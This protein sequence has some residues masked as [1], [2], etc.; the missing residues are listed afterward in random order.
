MFRSLLIIILGGVLAWLI[1]HLIR[2][3]RQVMPGEPAKPADP[4]QNEK[5]IDAEF[6]DVEQDDEDQGG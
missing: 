6:E 2:T 1:L 4:F 5:I 3:V